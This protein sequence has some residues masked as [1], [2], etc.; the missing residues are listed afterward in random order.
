MEL[1]SSFISLLTQVMWASSLVVTDNHVSAQLSLPFQFILFCLHGTVFCSQGSLF[2]GAQINLQYMTLAL[3][4]T[5][6]LVLPRCEVAIPS[7][8]FAAFHSLQWDPDFVESICQEI[9]S[10]PVGGLLVTSATTV[11]VA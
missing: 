5:M 7:R 2:L 11:V 6:S 10:C 1:I 3:P 4:Q 9:F 8:G